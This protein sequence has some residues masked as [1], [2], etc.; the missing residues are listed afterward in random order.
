MN[1]NLKIGD[2]IVAPRSGDVLEVCGILEDGSVEC[3]DCEFRLYRIPAGY[4]LV[5]LNT[6][7]HL[8]G[9]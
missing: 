5:K 9:W 2:E 7:G 3:I 8:E 1:T 6:T 4:N